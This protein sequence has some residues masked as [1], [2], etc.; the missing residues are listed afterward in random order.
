MWTTP[1]NKARGGVALTGTA[2]H[3]EGHPTGASEGANS[4]FNA[5]PSI[6]PV[7]SSAAAYTKPVGANRAR[8]YVVKRK[9]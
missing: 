7:S 2:V 8:R 1:T 3:Q 4:Q 6:H 5:K 9:K